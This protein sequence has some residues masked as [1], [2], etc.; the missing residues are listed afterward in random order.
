VDRI[1]H[2]TSRVAL[3]TKKRKYRNPDST[4]SSK[5]LS[6]SRRLDLLVRSLLVQTL[7]LDSGLIAFRYFLLKDEL[8]H[9]QLYRKESDQVVIPSKIVA[10]VVVARGMA[11]VTICTFLQKAGFSKL[12][13]IISEPAMATQYVN[14]S[15]ATR[16]QINYGRITT[17]FRITPKEP[18][19]RAHGIKKTQRR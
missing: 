3:R 10:T 19:R 15:V 17:G 2:N 16:R 18:T 4:R 5:I 12:P 14:I 1:R 7:C 13:K 11:Y 6:P 8:P 9:T